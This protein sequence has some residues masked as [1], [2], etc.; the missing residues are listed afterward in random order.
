MDMGKLGENLGL[1]KLGEMGLVNWVEGVGKVGG[2]CLGKHRFW[3]INFG[4]RSLVVGS[5]FRF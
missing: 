1:G 5:G 3:K 2:I 4:G